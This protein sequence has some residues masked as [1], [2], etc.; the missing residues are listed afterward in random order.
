MTYVVTDLCTGCRYTECVTVCPVACFHLDDQMTYI[1]P[2]NCIDCG[3]CAPACPV[4]AIVAD[5]LLPADKAA[6]LGIN[7]ERAAQTPVITSKLPPLPGAPD[8]PEHKDVPA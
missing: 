2:D 5:Y 6:W 3:G 4:G 1:D 8:L 7:R